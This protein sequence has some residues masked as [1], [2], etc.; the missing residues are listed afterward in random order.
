MKW[1]IIIPFIVGAVVVG[2]WFGPW[3]GIAAIIIWPIA[4]L[5]LSRKPKEFR[6]FMERY[7]RERRED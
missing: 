1:G 7:E 2:V 5:L 4:H 6:D 3:W